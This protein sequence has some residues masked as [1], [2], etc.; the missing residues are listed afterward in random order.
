MSSANANPNPTAE[1]YT[2]PSITPE[3]SR[4]PRR[5][6]TSD[7][8]AKA[9]KSANPLAHSSTTGATKTAVKKSASWT[10][11]AELRV[12]RNKVLKKSEITAA[13][14][15]PQRKTGTTYLSSSRS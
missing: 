4:P 15:N 8:T 3:N 2:I 6:D 13:T 9:I 10:L 1:P 5:K 14:V 12:T 11:T 7:A